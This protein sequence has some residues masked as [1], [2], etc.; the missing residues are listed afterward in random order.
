MASVQRITAR[1]A[2]VARATIRPLSRILLAEPEQARRMGEAGRR[3][4]AAH[5]RFRAF[6]DRFRAVLW[7]FLGL[8]AETSREQV[9]ANTRPAAR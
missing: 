3:R 8:E 9:G 5:F 6:R 7:P 4:W 2:C 1:L